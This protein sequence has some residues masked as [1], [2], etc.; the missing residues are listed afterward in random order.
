M[1]AAR[2]ITKNATAEIRVSLKCWRGEHRIDV[3]EFTATIPSIYMST[4]SGVTL[5]IA[6]LGEFIAAL[7]AVEAEAR[8]RGLIPEGRAS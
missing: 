1:T 7:H 5:P 4:A 8:A 6:K 3:R 2:V